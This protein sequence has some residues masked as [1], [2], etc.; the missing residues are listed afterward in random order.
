MFALRATLKLAC[1]HI[2][3]IISTNIPLQSKGSHNCVLEI[4]RKTNLNKFIKR[5]NYCIPMLEIYRKMV[6]KINQNARPLPLCFAPLQKLG[7][8]RPCIRMH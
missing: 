3:L 7:T 2:S 1:H 8:G 4:H 5:Q 6:I